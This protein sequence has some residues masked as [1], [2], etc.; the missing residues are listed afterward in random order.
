[1]KTGA[2]LE[3]LEKEGW[4]RRNVSKCL[5]AAVCRIVGGIWWANAAP[6]RY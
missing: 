6:C 3:K 4:K 2:I 1:M 5:A